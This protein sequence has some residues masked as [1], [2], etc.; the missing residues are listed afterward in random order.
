L[1]Q[2][3]NEKKYVE[4]GKKSEKKRK[5]REGKEKLLGQLNNLSE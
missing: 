1:I 3:E 5:K 2:G 4:E